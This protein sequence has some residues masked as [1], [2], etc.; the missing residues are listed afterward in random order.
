MQRGEAKKKRGLLRRTKE[1]D[2]IEDVKKVL[3]QASVQR[4]GWRRKCNVQ[5]VEVIS[6]KKDEG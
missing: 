3:K 4:L 5:G 2:R 6:R 1:S